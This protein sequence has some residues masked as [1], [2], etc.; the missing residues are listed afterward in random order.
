MPHQVI[1]TP[2]RRLWCIWLTFLIPIGSGCSERAK[3]GGSSLDKVQ[4]ILLLDQTFDAATIG[5][6]TTHFKPAFGV[7]DQ[8]ITMAEKPPLLSLLQQTKRTQ[9]AQP[10]QFQQGHDGTVAI[11]DFTVSSSAKMDLLIVLDNS[12]SMATEQ[13]ALSTGLPALISSLANVDWQIG[14]ITSDAET[15]SEPLAT[16]R[17]CHLYDDHGKAFDAQGNL[18]GTAIGK[19]DEAAAIRFTDT[20]Q[21]IGF[22]GSN[23]EQLIRN[24]LR[25]ITGTCGSVK[26][27]WLRKDALLG[28]LFVTDEDSFCLSDDPSGVKDAGGNTLCLPNERPEDLIAAL[29]P[30]Y[31]PENQV[32]VYS[33]TYHGAMPA[34][35]AAQA[36]RPAARILSVVNAFGGF[37]DSVQ[38]ADYS[39][40]L[41]RISAD[42]AKIVRRE[43]KLKNLPLNNSVQISVDGVNTTDYQINGNN[44]SVSGLNANTATLHVSYRHNPQ[45]IFTQVTTT[46]TPNL[47]TLKVTLNDIPLAQDQYTFDSTTNIV[48]FNRVPPDYSVIKVDYR[49]GPDPQLDFVV[50]NTGSALPI[51]VAVDGIPIT[52]YTWNK[53]THTVHFKSP[54]A[55]GAQIAISNK[56][57][58]GKITHYDQPPSAG[59]AQSMSVIDAATHEKIAVTVAGGQLIF[60]GDDVVAGRIATVTYHYG[61]KTTLLSYDLAHVPIEGSMTLKTADH[62]ADCLTNIKVAGQRVE[63]NCDAATLGELEL[64]YRYLISHDSTFTIGQDVPPGA[65]VQVF[66][67]GQAYS[68]Y[69]QTG[70]KFIIPVT[71]TTLTSKIRILINTNSDGASNSTI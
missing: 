46:Q 38:Q 24:T 25:A 6:E 62:N 31:F 18:T 13:T 69:E 29:K 12:S 27:E 4:P 17:G 43:F 1:D 30:P 19:N 8:N 15:A 22:G 56:D 45:P 66:V 2:L 60:S 40:T 57:P 14:I 65:F 36:Q 50:N 53:A 32:R 64:N 48:H 26:Q 11:E 68:H 70:R 54:P 41:A 47:A 23:R 42:A 39:N 28:I 10:D 59:S 55:E 67:D 16:N 63:F 9:L 37:D 58:D 33:L 61:D 49:I 5:V 35:G 7:V 20:I 52:D 3:F 21:N 34:P 51:A 71:D 44:I